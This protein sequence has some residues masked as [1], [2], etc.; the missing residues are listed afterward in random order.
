MQM[1]Q[2]KPIGEA[3]E[4]KKP[5][6]AMKNIDFKKAQNLHFSKGVSP[7]FLSKN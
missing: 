4:R 2:E 6:L 1:E 7:W 3:S 5:F